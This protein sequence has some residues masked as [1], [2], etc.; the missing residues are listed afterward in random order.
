MAASMAERVRQ[1]AAN[2]ADLESVTVRYLTYVLLPAWFLPGIGVLPAV[3]SLIA[4]PYAEELWR[5]A[6]PRKG[7]KGRPPP[8]PGAATPA[9]PG[10]GADAAGAASVI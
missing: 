9:V 1:A 4:L 10:S 7:W 2:P 6:R 5:S 8:A 3:T